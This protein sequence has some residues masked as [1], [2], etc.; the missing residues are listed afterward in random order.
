MSREAVPYYQPRSGYLPPGSDA[1][2]LA[3][4]VCPVLDNNH[5]RFPV[6]PPSDDSPDGGW[7][8]RTDCPVHQDH[9]DECAP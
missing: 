8:V 3:G 6:V 9:E 2:R 5:G 7:W 1:A 4:C